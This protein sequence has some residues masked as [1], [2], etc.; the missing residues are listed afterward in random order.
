MRNLMYRIARSELCGCLELVDFR[1]V[2]RPCWLS[3]LARNKDSKCTVSL[4][5]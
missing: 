5:T 2:F 4:F 1:Y 3:S